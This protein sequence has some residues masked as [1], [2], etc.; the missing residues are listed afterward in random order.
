M[1]TKIYSLFH[2]SLVKSFLLVVLVVS[3]AAVWSLSG[4][5]KPGPVMNASKDVTYAPNAINAVPFADIASAGPLS[6]VYL[7]VDLSCQ[8]RHVT[9]GTVN[10][11]F[12]PEHHTW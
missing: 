4:A 2:N 6:H 3:T 8:V 10:E 12:P 9:D 5:G 11:F 1:Q 7:G